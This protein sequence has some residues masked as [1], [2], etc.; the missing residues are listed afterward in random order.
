MTL[1]DRCE[2]NESARP[3]K[4]RPVVDHTLV[5]YEALKPFPRATIGRDLTFW[6]LTLVLELGT[7]D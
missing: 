2:K 1:D 6:H 5:S 3:G 7:W 4:T